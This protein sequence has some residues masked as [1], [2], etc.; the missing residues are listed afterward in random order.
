MQRRTFLTA[1][2]VTGATL[3][4]GCLSS[5]PRG[6]PA[7]TPSTTATPTAVP[8]TVPSTNDS[9]GQPEILSTTI[10]THD[11]SCMSGAGGSVDVAVSDDHIVID[12]VAQT[13]TPCH[14]AVIESADVERGEVILHIGFRGV[15]EQCVDCVGAIEYEA[16]LGM[17]GTAGVDSVTVVHDATGERFTYTRDKRTSTGNSPTKQPPNTSTVSASQQPDPDIDVILTNAH[18][19]THEFVVTI[20]RESGATVYEAT[21][22]VPAES[23]R[24]IYNLAE[25]DPAGIEAFTI[26]VVVGG[27]EEAITVKTNACY[28]N[29]FIEI[30]ADGELYPYY[31]IC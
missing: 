8:T 26:S 17:T 5:S 22:E 29:A 11:T 19:R 6:D 7:S 30:T 9:D 18:D 16:N 4:A 13:S 20:R 3:A 12:G 31:S 25:A 27:Q 15:G 1:F 24:E 2:G 28:G 21:H 23:R 10:E 14:E